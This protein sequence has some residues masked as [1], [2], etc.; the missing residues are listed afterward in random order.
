M[1]TY[2]IILLVDSSLTYDKVMAPD[3]QEILDRLCALDA[4]VVYVEDQ[5]GWT[6]AQFVEYASRVEKV[7]PEEFEPNPEL[8]EQVIDADVV[9]ANFA[10]VGKAVI[11]AAE[12]LKLIGVTRSGAEN[13]NIE[14]AKKAG[15]HVAVAPGRLVE[16]VSY[17]TIGMMIA[18]SRNIARMSITANNGEWL[19]TAQN[20]SYIRSLKGQ[21]VGII[22]FGIIGRRVAE[23]LRAFGC[24]IVAY[25]PFLP[26]QVFAQ[27][28]ARKVELAELMEVSDFV[29]VHARLTK[30][31]EGLV[32]AE[33]IAKMKPHAF[34]VNTARAGLVD[35]D[36][37]VEALATHKIGGAALDVFI[38]EPIPEGHP[39]LALDNVTLTPHRA[40]YCSNL[41]ALSLDIIVSDVER[42][43]KGEPLAH[44]KC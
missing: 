39:I 12:K 1:A 43:L 4:E 24:K 23:K 3:A 36:A 11:D 44:P 8:L 14:A 31:T 17:Y 7:G 22:G 16:P 18:E 9:L 38:E 30:D 40:G 2:K 34:F 28:D 6:R 20:A 41:A 26:D 5:K 27:E 13:I 37:L 35:M 42:L 19:D 21:T 15:V 33:M 32:S 29:S 10:P 25:D